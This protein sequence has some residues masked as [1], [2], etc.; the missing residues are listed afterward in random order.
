M[1]FPTVLYFGLIMFLKYFSFKL[2]FIRSNM[3]I[4]K[5]IFL[6]KKHY[7]LF[8]LVVLSL[9]RTPPEK[10]SRSVQNQCQP[11]RLSFIRLLILAPYV[12]PSQH[13]SSSRELKTFA[14]K[15]RWSQSIFIQYSAKRHLRKKRA[16]G[17]LS[18]D[19]SQ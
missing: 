9:Q 16:F 7:I 15:I 13:R 12:L 14:H 3:L 1:P 11:C 5:I 6:K 19:P 17:N 2:I 8:L 4:I 18:R 10:W